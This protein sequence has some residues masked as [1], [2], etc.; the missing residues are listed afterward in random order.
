MRKLLSL[1][2]AILM[3]LA[4]CVPVMAESVYPLCENL[5]DV[6]LK[7]MVVAHPA[8]A[9]WDTNASTK[10]MEG[11]TNVKIDWLTVPYEGRA[12]ATQMALA[13]SEYPDV[14]ML[15][16]SGCINQDVLNRYGVNEQRLAV[17]ND[18]I[19]QH[20]PNLKEAF[21]KNPGY[22][23][24]MKM[25][26]GNIYSLPTINQCYHCT[27]PTKLW[28]NHEW[29]AALNLSIPTTIEE[30]YNVLVQFRDGDPNGNG[31]KDEI[32][33][34]GSYITGWNS[35]A[36]YFLMN[37]FTFYDSFLMG[38]MS[39]K[40]SLGFYLDGDTVKTPFAE[41]GMLE[42]L[43]FMNKLVSEGLLYDGS[44]TMDQESLVNLVENPSAELV[45][46]AAGGYG[47]IFSNMDGDRYPHFSALMPLEGPD[48]L[49]QIP[50]NPYDLGLAGACISADSPNVEIAAKWI[51]KLYSFEGSAVTTYGPE[52]IG[53]RYPTD[54]EL[55]INGEPA[56]YTQLKPWQEVEPQEDHWVQ[57]TVTNRDSDWRLGMT[58]DQETP[59][60]S[61][62]GLEKLLYD[63]SKEMMQFADPSKYMPPVKF[64][65]ED[66]DAMSIAM[67]E[68][69]NLI[70]ECV[71]QFMMGTMSIDSEY[72]G[73]L[74]N[75]EAAGLPML[76]EK[77]QA[78]YD[79]Q[80]KN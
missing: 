30:F 56:L 49:R 62:D 52:G 23:D 66:T 10:W 38:D 27:L 71:P 21:E 58:F 70:K 17:L 19:D 24:M 32:P 72:D 33:M 77:Y 79:A 34:A 76:T 8:I 48:G 22:E 16:Y 80:F 75:L 11:Q 41:P 50:V 53:W 28:I 55:G 6:T 3:C 63:V 47:G 73:F 46:V 35:M 13:G 65:T 40:Y 54:G 57:A 69:G 74:A 37:S 51:D 26:D 42:G 14:F 36:D 1:C 61:G 44:F 5:G 25:L 2:L 20:M 31:L 18:V 4:L 43:K 9:N 45:G 7:V 78:A 12:E 67:V 15:P 64:T 60:Y 39:G 68:V 29:L 59:L